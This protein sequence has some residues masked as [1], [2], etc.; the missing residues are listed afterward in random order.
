[1]AT[2]DMLEST[3][4]ADKLGLK[5]ERVLHG[6][7]GRVVIKSKDKDCLRK[8]EEEFKAKAPQLVGKYAFRQPKKS[9]YRVSIKFVK[10]A[11]KKE[12]IPAILEERVDGI[13]SENVKVLFEIPIKAKTH[14][15]I[16]IAV[17]EQSRKTL[18]KKGRINFGFEMS[19]IEDYINVKTC[20][21][22]NLYGHIS[23]DCNTPPEKVRCSKC[24]ENHERKNC[25]CKPEDEIAPSCDNCINYNKRTK[26]T[27]RHLQTDHSLKDWKCGVYRELTRKALERLSLQ[28]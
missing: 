13:N 22:C 6:K 7:E 14:K 16:I 19:P 8:I 23:T 18:L 11:I 27:N 15:H 26:G 2:Y 3:I 28:F 12:E 25:K 4:D 9:D 24:G 1:M 5:F 20:Y 21:R 10:N 17:D